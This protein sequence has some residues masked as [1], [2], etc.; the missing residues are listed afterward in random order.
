MTFIAPR[1]AKFGASSLCLI[2]IERKKPC[3]QM[4]DARRNHCLTPPARFLAKTQLSV[5]PTSWRR[6][7]PTAA[8]G[9]RVNFKPRAERLRYF[10]AADVGSP[11]GLGFHQD[12]GFGSLSPYVGCYLQVQI[13]IRSPIT[14]DFELGP[15][16]WTRRLGRQ[17]D[18]LPPTGHVADRFASTKCL[19]RSSIRKAR[20]QLSIGWTMRCETLSGV[21]ACGDKQIAQALQDWQQSLRQ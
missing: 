15:R 17:P 11:I 7:A 20:A 14:I 16:T 19:P 1:P 3:G 13:K 18:N 9:K 5:F 8:L 12:I 4:C 2:P 10:V 6:T 21:W